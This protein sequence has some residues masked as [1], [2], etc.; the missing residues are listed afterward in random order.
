M[1]DD[2]YR[3]NAIMR[4]YRVGNF[5]WKNNMKK[6][7][8]IVQWIGMKKTGNDI[9]SSAHIDKSVYF[10]HPIGIVIGSGVRIERDVTIH[11]NVIIGGKASPRGEGR[12]QYKYPRIQE[13]SVIYGNSCLIGDI[14]IR[15][16]SIIGAGSVVIRSTARGKTYAGCPAREIFSID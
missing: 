16:N 8:Y 10:P 5:L 6:L 13:G 15:R 3:S 1:I 14:W 4:Y 9:S 11:A 7:A 12:T 2:R